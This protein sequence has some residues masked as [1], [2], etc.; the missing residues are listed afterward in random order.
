MNKNITVPELSYLAGIIE[1]KGVISFIYDTTK[2][3]ANYPEFYPSLELI[4]K[5][6][7]LVYSVQSLVQCGTVSPRKTSSKVRWKILLKHKDCVEVLEVIKPYVSTENFK[8]QIFVTEQFYKWKI[9]IMAGKLYKLNNLKYVLEGM[10][11]F[12]SLLAEAKQLKTDGNF[13]RLT[14]F[15][16]L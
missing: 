1:V 11:R 2:T 8:R 12:R 14:S 6:K 16:K 15:K 10:E 9:K 3:T 4:L 7:E 5:D 13:S